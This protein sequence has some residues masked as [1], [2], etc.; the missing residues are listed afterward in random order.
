M[1]FSRAAANLSFNLTPPSG[2]AEET[3][4]KLSTLR[5]LSFRVA[6]ATALRFLT[7][8]FA[9][10]LDC[11]IWNMMSAS[12]TSNV[13]RW[14]LS[15]ANAGAISDAQAKVSV[16]IQPTAISTSGI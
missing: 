6:F 1:F 10:T 15:F 13:S 12:V 4:V 16:A 8:S 5:K 9:L 3:N 7:S 2:E 14:K 11:W